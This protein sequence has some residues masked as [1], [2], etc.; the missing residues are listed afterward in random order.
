M[1]RSNTAP[2]L[3]R[4]SARNG[5]RCACNYRFQLCEQMVADV[6]PVLLGS[7]A[8]AG[9]RSRMLPGWMSWTA[10][11]L[12]VASVVSW[13][14]WIAFW[15]DLLW[16]GAAGFFLVLRLRPVEPTST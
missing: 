11:V 13:V 9:L 6:T 16:M 8:V 10:A 2:R 5:I 3:N 12:A 4:G 14:V 1:A 7:A 15:L